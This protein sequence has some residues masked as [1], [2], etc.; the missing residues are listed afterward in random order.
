M[1]AVLIPAL[2]AAQTLAEAITKI[3]TV[4][5]GSWI[6]VV[7]DGSTDETAGIAEASG[8]NVVRHPVNRGKGAALTTGFDHILH[9]SQAECVI[10]LDADLQ[11]D[12]MEIPRF[13][14]R[15]ERG[16]ADLIVGHRR[17]TGSGMPMHRRMSNQLTSFL[18]SARTGQAIRDSQCGFRC[19]GRSVLTEVRCSS[20]G[21]EAETEM[22]IRAAQH[23]F[24][25]DFVPISTIYDGERSSMTHWQTTRR[26]LEVLLKEY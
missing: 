24:V 21:F 8:A 6:V 7:D 3:K 19:I 17:K 2:N 18:V 16:T 25:I 11:H 12:P 15:W 22:L 5:Q 13:I 4:L 9:T 20:S 1:I 10:T 23:G 26:F 14:S